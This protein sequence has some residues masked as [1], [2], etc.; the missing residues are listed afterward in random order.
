M[1]TKTFYLLIIAVIITVTLLSQLFYCKTE[2]NAWWYAIF[3]P[4]QFCFF[5]F[6]GYKL[7]YK[8]II[9][10]TLMIIPIF[11]LLSFQFNI[12]ILQKLLAIAIGGLLFVIIMWIIRKIVL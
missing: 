3:L 10:W 6:L 4:C 2:G 7:T 9:L 11:L 12:I 5:G 8:N 1:K